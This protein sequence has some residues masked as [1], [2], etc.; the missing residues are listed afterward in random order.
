MSKQNGT[1]Y[2]RTR[3]A[4]LKTLFADFGTLSFSKDDFERVLDR[5]PINIGDDRTVNKYWNKL[6]KMGYIQ[7]VNRT[8]ARLTSKVV[9]DGVLIFPLGV[10]ETEIVAEVEAPL[11]MNKEALR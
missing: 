9:Q 6:L 5:D 4:I 10:A 3:D 8:A 1:Q 2:S 11:Q 7:M